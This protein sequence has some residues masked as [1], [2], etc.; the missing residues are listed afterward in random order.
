MSEKSSHYF[1][2]CK[3]RKFGTVA[4][5]EEA[6]DLYRQLNGQ[7]MKLV[8]TLPEPLQ[9]DA[10]LFMMRYAGIDMGEGLD[11]FRN[12]YVPAWTT[13]Y[14]TMNAPSA[15]VELPEEE[16]QLLLC[17]HAMAM[18]LHSLDDHLVDGDL[19]V[20][21]LLLALRSQGWLL[22]RMSLEDATAGDQEQHEMARTLTEEY[23]ATI[24]GDDAT[25]TLDEYC[26]LFRGQMATWTVV[27]VLTA[28]KV[29]ENRKVWVDVRSAYESFGIAWR[30]LDDV[31]DVEDD[32][33]SGARTA[34]YL[35]L[36]EEGR[37]LWDLASTDDRAMDRL[38]NTMIEEAVAET[39]LARAVKEL[40]M[41]ESLA[42]GHGMDGLA[43]EFWLLAEPLVGG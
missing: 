43:G 16:L 1:N 42:G 3:N 40:M 18:H 38:V 14:W 34:M 39:V 4:P 12:Y 41:A 2:W 19:A 32:I 24:T 7:V 37:H 30:L 26:A 8:R 22:L 21:H 6:G 29:S 25:D 31:Q 10:M 5:P 9:T 36:G 13:M 27:P 20:S 17:A 35:A 15:S 23:Y 28:M 11:L 33:N